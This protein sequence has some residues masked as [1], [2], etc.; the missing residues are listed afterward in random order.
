MQQLH[1]VKAAAPAQTGT[2][3]AE[4]V[5]LIA[6]LRAPGGCPWDAEQTHASIASNM[7][8]E[9]CEAVD[10]I[11]ADDAEHLKEEL[12]DVLLEVVLQAQI[13]Q[14]AGEFTIDD[15]I[16][17]I[18]AKIVRRHPHVF[19]AETSLV[20]A[21]FSP[22]EIEQATS[23]GAVTDMWEHI[24]ARERVV[25]EQH[26]R[27][28][29]LAAGRDPEEPAGLLDD[30]PRSLPALQQ[31]QKI[32]KR[33]VAAGFEW[34]SVEDVWEKVDEERAEF[35]QAEPGTPDAEE[36]LGDILFTLVNVAR[37][38]HIDAEGALRRACG[39]FR[40]RW[41]IMEQLARREY[42]APLESLERDVLEELWN[43]AKQQLRGSKQ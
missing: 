36:E 21:G 25:K 39:K 24:K 38:E 37:K 13:A 6:A 17:G 33:A 27:E 12:G 26:R 10:A 11:E 7:L 42:G 19:G 5:A 20:A 40:A 35:E 14:D 16:A 8:E 29:A 2:A 34:D 22:E 28:Q 4:F 41:S 31:A 32:S 1:D 23:P 30:V 3:F 18:D 9:A 43:Q 15:V